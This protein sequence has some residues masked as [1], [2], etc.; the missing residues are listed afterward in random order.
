MYKRKTKIVATLG[1]A[2]QSFDMIKSLATAGVDIFR[3]NFSHGSHESHIQNALFVREASK[4][5]N[6]PLEILMDLQGPKIRVGIFLNG[7]AVLKSGAKFILDTNSQPGDATRCLLPHSELFHII[8]VG[9]ELLLDDGK[10]K[11]LVCQNNGNEIETK[12][13]NSGILSSHKGVNIPNVILPIPA[14]TDKDKS[15]IKILNKINPNWL[16]LSF[17]QSASD[18]RFAKKH[19]NQNLK[20]VA[21]IE[22]PSA[23]DGINEILKETDAVIIARGDLGIEIPFETIPIIQFKIIKQANDHAKP[24]IV[25]TQMLESMINNQFPTRAEV[26]DIAYAV[27]CGADAVMLS[28]E[29]AS[30]NN[31]IECVKI[32]D[33][34]ASKIEQEG[35]YF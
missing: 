5:L 4:A 30:G 28:A 26:T 9:T 35:F 22:T 7:Q 25:A 23:V 1:P 24:V 11:L 12:V 17:V 14:L 8:K 29:T 15:D 34:V 27:A 19:I 18:I 21:K 32:M 20:I 31:P 2:S 13:I 10:I 33:K 16:A 3:L 6:K